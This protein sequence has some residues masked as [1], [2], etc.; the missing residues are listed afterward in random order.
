MSPASSSYGNVP[1]WKRR[2]GGVGG[3]ARLVRP[4]RVG[5]RLAHVGEAEVRA[6]ELVG[7][8]E[9]DVGV[10]GADVDRLVRRVVDGVDPGEC[11]GSVGE[12]ADACASVTVPTAFEAQ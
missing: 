11:P 5:E 1:V 4:P 3:R 8:A 2:P 12:L 7:R 9:Q 6:A 10:D